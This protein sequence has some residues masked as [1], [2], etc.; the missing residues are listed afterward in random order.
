MGAY[1]SPELAAAGHSVLEA[2][3]EGLQYNW[4]SRGPTADGHV[5]VAFSAPGGAIAPVPQW[6]QQV[7]SAAWAWGPGS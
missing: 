4:S 5:G 3:A 1:V 6:T 2:P 7:G